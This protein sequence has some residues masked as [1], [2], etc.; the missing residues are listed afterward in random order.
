[1]VHIRTR[2]IPQQNSLGKK[3]PVANDHSNLAS[4]CETATNTYY[5]SL[6]I[7]SIHRQLHEPANTQRM[8]A[9]IVTSALQLDAKN[10]Y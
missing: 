8:L 9:I 3:K 2:E 4:K 7:G 10:L 6:F 1:L 5:K